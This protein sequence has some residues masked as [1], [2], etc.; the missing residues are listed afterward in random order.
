MGFSAKG[1]AETNLRRNG[2]IGD[3]VKEQ[4]CHRIAQNGWGCSGVEARNLFEWMQ[5]NFDEAQE[6]K[7][8]RGTEVEPCSVGIHD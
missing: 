6:E 3:I 7:L 4:D 2:R 5:R 1:N 8:R